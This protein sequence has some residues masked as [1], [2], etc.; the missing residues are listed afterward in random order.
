[1][2]EPIFV[3]GHKNPDNDSI[4]S[5]VAYAYLKN[6][7][8]RRAIE[9][10]QQVEEVVYLPVCLGPVPAESAWVLAENGFETPALIQSVQPG[11]KLVLVDHNEAQQAVDGLE[12]AD[13]LTIIDHHRIGS[14]TTNNPIEFINLP[15]GSTA[16]IITVLFRQ[17]DVPICKEIGCVLLSAILTDTVITKS[18]TTTDVD[19]EQI[20]YLSARI[21]VDATEYGLSLFACRSSEDE[22]PIEELVCA[23]S[24]EFK[25]GTSTAL[26]AQRE[27]VNLKGV[28]AREEEMRAHLRTLIEAK[29]YEFAL[30]LVTDIIAEGSQFL[31]EGDPSMVERVFNITCQPGGTWMPGV[32]SRKKQVA[33][34]LLGA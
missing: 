17:F 2:G 33:A 3:V 13:L 25:L 4:S 15:W 29:G 23:D 1:M 27:T 31:V 12:D 30:L 20:A 14:I 22:M 26:I 5:A 9:E 19:R 10:G 18:P 8:N 16:T 24:K 32:L 7:L 28:M 21:G 6:A 11:Q 34:P